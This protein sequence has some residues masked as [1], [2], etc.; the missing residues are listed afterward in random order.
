M[1]ETNAVKVRP[2]SPLKVEVRAKTAVLSFRVTAAE[3]EAFERLLKK[4]GVDPQPMLLAF[5]K[6]G[7]AKA[8]REGIERV[9]TRGG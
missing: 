2:V 7:M 6:D 5:F 9:E 3:Y 8:E 4:H 1:P